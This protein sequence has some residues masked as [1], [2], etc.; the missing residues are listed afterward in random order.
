MNGVYLFA[1]FCELTSAVIV[2]ENVA[3]KKINEVALTRS[4]WLSTFIIDTLPYYNFF[5]DIILRYVKSRKG[6]K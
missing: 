5:T 3:F 6:S 1:L 4:K 2:Y